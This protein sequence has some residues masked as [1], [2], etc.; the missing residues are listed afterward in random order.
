[1]FYAELIHITE[2]CGLPVA[3]EPVADIRAV[4]S[5]LPGDIGNLQRW[6][7][8]C[9]LCQHQLFDADAYFVS[10]RGD[11]CCRF[12]TRHFRYGQLGNDGFVT[13]DEG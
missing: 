12:I 7:E 13:I 6:H 10:F 1:M 2:E 11:F 5:Y 4:T 8:I 9:S 3:V